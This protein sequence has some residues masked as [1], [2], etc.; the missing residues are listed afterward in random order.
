MMRAIAKKPGEDFKVVNVLN[1]LEALQ[2]YVGGY[3]EVVQLYGDVA[4]IC[5]EEG[6]LKKQEYNCTVDGISFVGNILFIGTE[7]EEFG[8]LPEDFVEDFED[9]IKDYVD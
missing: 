4:I 5:N 8:D 1:T 2:E 3:I 7:G 6:R 9:Y